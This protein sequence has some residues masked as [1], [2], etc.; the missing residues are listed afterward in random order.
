MSRLPDLPWVDGPPDDPRGDWIGARADEIALDVAEATRFVDEDFVAGVAELVGYMLVHYPTSTPAE[1]AEVKDRLYRVWCRFSDWA[2]AQAAREY[3]D[4]RA[5]A[6][7]E[8]GLARL[9]AAP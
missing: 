8:R 2:E 9:E 6:E 3:E 7:L 1:A 4:A 5:D